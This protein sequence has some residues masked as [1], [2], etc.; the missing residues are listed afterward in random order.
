MLYVCL[1]QFA[2]FGSPLSVCL[3]RFASFELSLF[4]LQPADQNGEIRGV[5]PL[6]YCSSC[7]LCVSIGKSTPKARETFVGSSLSFFSVLPRAPL[8]ALL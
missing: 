4:R 1:F 7:K 3:F 6:L 8:L 5:L 2:S